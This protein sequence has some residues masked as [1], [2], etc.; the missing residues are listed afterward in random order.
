MAYRTNSMDWY[1]ADKK[2]FKGQRG[3]EPVNLPSA[4]TGSDE[5]NDDDIVD[6]YG[7]KLAIADAAL[8]S[9][10]TRSDTFCVWFILHGYQQADVENLSQRDPLIPTLAKRF[11]MIVDRTN[12]I[13]KGGQAANPALPRSSPLTSCSPS[14][15]EGAGGWAGG[16]A[17][18][19]KAAPSHRARQLHHRSCRLR[20]IP[21]YPSRHRGVIGGGLYHL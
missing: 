4:A 20:L 3:I 19:P 11:M 13:K 6:D 21:G 18:C 12:V 1:A 5:R 16:W 7:E 9:I 15:R 2:T 10:T 14:L 8:N 17:D